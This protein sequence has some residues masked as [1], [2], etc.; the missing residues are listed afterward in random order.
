MNGL[1]H[2]A[3]VSD[4]QL[5]EPGQPEDKALLQW[6]LQQI[7]D[8]A[9]RNNSLLQITGALLYSGGQ[10][11]QV[12]EGPQAAINDRFRRISQDVRHTHVTPLIYEPAGERQFA[13]WSMV[14]CG[15]AE[16]HDLPSNLEEKPSPGSVEAGDLGKSIVTSLA[17]AMKRRSMS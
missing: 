17:T 2:L 14:L 13:N 6:Q 4:A 16:V 8:T 1:Y 15:S 9:K 10:F 5:F 7:L 12:L 11:A 3:Y